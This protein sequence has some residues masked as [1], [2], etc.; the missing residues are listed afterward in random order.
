[1]E[2]TLDGKD[3]T[4]IFSK[5][6]PL[7]DLDMPFT[8]TGRYEFQSSDLQPKKSS[9]KSFCF[10]VIWIF[11]LLLIGM[12]GYLAYKVFNLEAL[13]NSH[14]RDSPHAEMLK[15][16]LDGTSQA[17]V[18]SL[19]GEEKA[20]ESLMTQLHLLNSSSNDLQNQVNTIELK[21]GPPGLPGPTGPPGISGPPGTLGPMGPPGAKGSDGQPGAP[22]AKGDTGV[23]GVP[24]S[25]G[26]KGEKGDAGVAGPEGA[27]GKIGLPG[28]PGLKGE[29]G[30]TGAPGFPGQ[31][32]D[33]GIPG[34]PGVPGPPGRTGPPGS[35]GLKG[36]TGV[37]GSTGQP[38][39][40]GPPGARGPDGLQGPAGPK[41]SS[42][43]K[44]Q[45]GDNN[46]GPPG[47]PGLKGD[48][49]VPGFPG[50]PGL[51]G[52]QGSKGD[53]GSSGLAGLKGDMGPRGE[54][55]AKGDQGLPGPKGDKGDQG[56]TPK[57]IRLV[58]S[59]NR[60][61]VEVLYNGQ[62]G[63]VC[64]DNFDTLDGTVVCK[65]L[66]FERALSVFKASPGTGRVLL[67]ELRCTGRESSLFD[68]PHN[69]IGVNDCT[70]SED[71][72]VSCA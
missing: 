23:A 68:C 20:L 66:G 2:T 5:E 42:G 52:Q 1:M 10:P 69:G 16:F 28:N 8:S 27:A 67:D 49:G 44:G 46:S 6:N 35:L 33:K 25:E 43:E 26:A 62:W 56:S 31:K 41:G 64:D 4:T 32:G 61:R 50:V 38:G 29:P 17:C 59:S 37:K 11:L 13:V 14:H 24:G 19:C 15:S 7:Y 47:P 54:Q 57:V 55:G 12:N 9:G 71:A 48:K 3:K 60:G 39:P 63:T 65:M 40:A 22:G 21:R 70:H 36:S 72:G 34:L 58:G 45:S 30:Q 53:T 18:S 51:K